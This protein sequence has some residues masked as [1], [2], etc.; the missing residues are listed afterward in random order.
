MSN[1][2]SLNRISQLSNIPTVDLLLTEA[3]ECNVTPGWVERDAPLFLPQPKGNFIPA[4]WRYNE[5]KAL[6]DSAGRLIDVAVGLALPNWRLS[7]LPLDHQNIDAQGF[8]VKFLF[9]AANHPC[10]I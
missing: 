7:L 4:Q 2:A 1:T 10:W 3:A 8:T 9:I 6:M 5:M